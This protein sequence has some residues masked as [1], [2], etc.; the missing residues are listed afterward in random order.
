MDAGFLIKSTETGLAEIS[1]KHGCS[2]VL[3]GSSKLRAINMSDRPMKRRTACAE[4]QRAQE[5]QA[6]TVPAL[7]APLE[8]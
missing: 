4:I 2:F 7:E 3:Y 8:S 6:H 5:L 1:P